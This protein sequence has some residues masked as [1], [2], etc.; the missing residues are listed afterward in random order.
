MIFEK[1]AFVEAAYVTV[2][3]MTTVG[4]GDFTSSISRGGTYVF[5]CFFIIG[6]LILIAYVINS[7][8]EIIV[9][10]PSDYF[11]SKLRLLEGIDASQRTKTFTETTLTRLWVPQAVIDFYMKLNALIIA[12]IF[13]CIFLGIGAIFFAVIEGCTCQQFGQP[14]EGCKVSECSTTGGRTMSFGYALYMCI[15][16]LS[17][18]GFGD[19]SPSTHGGMW[20]AIFW[21]VL[22]VAV[23]ANFVAAMIQFFVERDLDTTYHLKCKITRE[24]F[25]K[26]DRN[27]DG[28][29]SKAEFRRFVLLKFSL[30]E[31]SI[32]DEIDVQYEYLK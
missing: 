21:I 5:L 26:M 32:L 11:R 6:S 20:F 4:Y 7:L 12:S 3:I 8:V 13:C 17:T 15:V 2:Q 31:E 25:D 29:I 10:G 19:Y 27:Q 24:M 1:F 9:T 23:F 28:T 30:I 22:G 14:I 16:T 18:C